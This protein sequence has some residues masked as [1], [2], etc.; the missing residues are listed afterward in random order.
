M[1]LKNCSQC[2]VLFPFAGRNICN[3]CLEKLEEEY[4]VV[5]KYVRD[6]QGASV[7]EVSR[8]TGIEEEI[9]LLFIRD[10]RLKSQGFKNILECEGCGQSISSGRFCEDCLAKRDKEI[11]GVL[12]GVQREP[13]SER[14]VRKTNDKLYIRDRKK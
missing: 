12:H 5:R 3:K 4:K 1:S 14:T 7:F 6:H 11:R 2:G 9:V 8:D 13:V 10:G